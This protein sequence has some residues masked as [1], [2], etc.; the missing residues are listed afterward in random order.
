VFSQ[1]TN[2]VIGI[3]EESWRWDSFSSSSILFYFLPKIKLTI[4]SSSIYFE[5]TWMHQ[6]NSADGIKTSIGM[7]QTLS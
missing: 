6:G 2:S 4:L 1:A 7:N 5:S 3:L